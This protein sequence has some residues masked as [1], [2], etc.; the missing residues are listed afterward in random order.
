MQKG[1]VLPQ[2]FDRAFTYGVRA[3]PSFRKFTRNAPMRQLGRYGAASSIA[4]LITMATFTPLSVLGSNP[5]PSSAEHGHA[6]IPPQ[7]TPSSFARAFI[8]KSTPLFE[9]ASTP[10]K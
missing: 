5:L 2:A 4:S 9:L 1:T 8:M 10:M 3:N 7:A 6:S